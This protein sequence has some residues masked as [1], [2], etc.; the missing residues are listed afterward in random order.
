MSVTVTD[1]ISSVV[2]GKQ[3]DKCPLIC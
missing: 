1:R 3:R 2:A